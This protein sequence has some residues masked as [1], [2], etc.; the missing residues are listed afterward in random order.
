MRTP[1]TA[2]IFARDIEACRNMQGHDEAFVDRIVDDERAYQAEY[3]RRFDNLLAQVRAIKS[4]ADRDHICKLLAKLGGDGCLS[5]TLEFDATNRAL[6]LYGVTPA[7][8]V[9]GHDRAVI[10][11]MCATAKET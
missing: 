1:Q 9:F 3:D 8:G 5:G 11:G 4:P 10:A 2:I 6:R 7:T